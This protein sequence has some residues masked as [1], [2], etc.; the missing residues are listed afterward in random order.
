MMLSS[1]ADLVI[2]GA[3]ERQERRAHWPWLVLLGVLTVVLD[4]AIPC[5]RGPGLG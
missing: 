3:L 1:Q 2:D 5:V 4:L